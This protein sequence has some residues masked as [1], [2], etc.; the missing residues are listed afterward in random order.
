MHRTAIVATATTAVL[1]GALLLAAAQSDQSDTLA[2]SGQSASGTTVA[3]ERDG[4]RTQWIEILGRDGVLISVPVTVDDGTTPP[5]TEAGPA[6]S[7]DGTDT[8]APVTTAGVRVRPPTGGPVL[9]V[10]TTTQAALPPTPTTT[11]KPVTSTTKPPVTTTKPPVTT[12]K[13]PVTTVKPPATTSTTTTTTTV[14][15]TDP[16]P[17]PTTQPPPPPPPT[18]APNTPFP[19]D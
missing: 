16:P 12:V 2:L 5:A 15:V 13:P 10:T 1:V 4:H 18:T 11:V 14:P 8:T 7:A 6:T 3:P 9:Y 17:P 19:V